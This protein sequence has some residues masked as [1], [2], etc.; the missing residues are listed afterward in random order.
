MRGAIVS[1]LEIDIWN[2]K[3]F[4]SWKVLQLWFFQLIFPTW[5]KECLSS[6]YKWNVALCFLYSTG[7]PPG[8][9]DNRLKSG[10]F[11]TSMGSVEQSINFQRSYAKWLR[12]KKSF[13]DSDMLY[14]FFVLFGNYPSK[15]SR[16]TP[17]P[18]TPQ[19]NI[20][21]QKQCLNFNSSTMKT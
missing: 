14:S 12:N 20:P 7:T 17:N 19:P 13:W 18:P 15:I 6:V 5:K 8:N 21:K 1:N 10:S 4:K 9:S 3:S 16:S 11:I 2:S